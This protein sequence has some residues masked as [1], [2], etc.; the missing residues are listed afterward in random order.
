MPSARRCK[1]TK[2]R[3]LRAWGSNFRGHFGTTPSYKARGWVTCLVL[4]SDECQLD[5]QLSAY[6]S[7]AP[8]EMAGLEGPEGLEVA[9]ALDLEGRGNPASGGSAARTGSPSAR[10]V[11]VA[12][13]LFAL[14]GRG[15]SASGGSAAR[16]GSSARVVPVVSGEA[17]PVSPPGWSHRAGW[18]SATARPGP[19]LRSSRSR[20]T[21]QPRDR[22]R[23]C[24]GYRRLSLRR[25]IGDRRGQLSPVQSHRQWRRGQSRRPEGTVARSSCGTSAAEGRTRQRQRSKQPRS[26]WQPRRMHRLHR[27][28][29]M[30]SI[31]RTG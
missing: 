6:R 25:G 13:A 11:P 15:N 21:V 23:R 14:R 2:R 17:R 4:W 27:S 30:T 16:Q 19:L 26:R 18:V 1:L 29:Q 10:V 9:Q 7:T 24:G 22:T 20:P 12:Q 28:P 5:W 8:G 3:R 31:E